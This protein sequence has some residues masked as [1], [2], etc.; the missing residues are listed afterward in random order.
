MKTLSPNTVL[1]FSS[2]V[3]NLKCCFICD[4]LFH[5]LPF[6][7]KFLLC[8]MYSSSLLQLG[9]VISLYVKMAV[10]TLTLSTLQDEKFVYPGVDGACQCFLY[11]FGLSM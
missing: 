4:V 3:A 10:E 6:L 9:V 11:C 8:L 5:F 7:G 1:H 2:P